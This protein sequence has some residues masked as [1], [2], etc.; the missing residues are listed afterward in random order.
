MNAIIKK[1][2]LW[3]LNLTYNYID[4]DNDGKISKTELEE[5]VYYPIM[6]LIKRI[7]KKRNK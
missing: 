2:L 1:I 4:K 7:N 6:K 3:A 5:E